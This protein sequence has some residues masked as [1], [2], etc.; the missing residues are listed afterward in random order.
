MLP[1]GR[2][3]PSSS[4][5]AAENPACSLSFTVCTASNDCSA[6]TKIGPPLPISWL[7][8]IHN[9]APAL[10]PTNA[11]KRPSPFTSPS[12]TE[13]LSVL[14]SCWSYAV[15]IPVPSFSKIRLSSESIVPMVGFP[16]AANT[17][18]SPSP[19]TSPSAASRMGRPSRESIG[20]ICP[21]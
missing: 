1:Y 19:S 2:Y 13:V 10:V 9:L 5:A 4:S 14:P 11:S 3:N 8:L 18:R 15:N 16:T 20:V 12:A 6:G 17:S 7:W 21:V